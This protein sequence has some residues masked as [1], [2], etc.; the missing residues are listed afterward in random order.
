MFTR[1]SNELYHY[2]IKGMKWGVRRFQNEDGSYK[3]GAEGRYNPDGLPGVH[4]AKAAMAKVREKLRNKDFRDKQRQEKPPKPQKTPEELEAE[5]ERHKK[6]LRN[7]AIGAGVAV[8]AAVVYKC[9][10]TYVNNIKAQ[11]M[12]LYQQESEVIFSTI[13]NVKMADVNTWAESTEK[14]L[15]DAEDAFGAELAKRGK[16]LDDF[17]KQISLE[18]ATSETAGKL[19]KK[20]MEFESWKKAAETDLREKREAYDTEKALR[21]G[22]AARQAMDAVNAYQAQHKKPMRYAGQD[23]SFGTAYKRVYNYKKY[24]TMGGLDQAIDGTGN[25]DMSADFKASKIVENALLGRGS[26]RENMRTYVDSIK[27]QNAELYKKEA[28]IIFNR[29]AGV[30]LNEI[31]KQQI[32]FGISDAEKRGIE[33]FKSQRRSEAINAARKVAETYRNKHDQNRNEDD[34]ITAYRRVRNYRR[35]GALDLAKQLYGG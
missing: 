35:H 20:N 3:A 10:K 5:K 21:S 25:A 6:I 27:Q 32:Q 23:D 8:G 17:R 2:G 31:D 4:K 11:N 18:S 24:G 33:Q 22:D 16:D 7:V 29:T 13:S 15:K 19:H 34:F 14:Q 28:N 1:F 26:L 12:A 9:G 30:K